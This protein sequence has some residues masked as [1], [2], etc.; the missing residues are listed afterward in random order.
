MQIIGQLRQARSL[1]CGCLGFPI[2]EQ[3]CND[4][5]N[6]KRSHNAKKR[7]PESAPHTQVM[8]N[9]G[10]IYGRQKVSDMHGQYREEKYSSIRI[11]R[12]KEKQVKSNDSPSASGYA[13]LQPA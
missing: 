9:N 12:I 2:Q 10:E 8:K 4:Q 11:C 7:N 1:I 6:D 13:R 5:Y 3:S